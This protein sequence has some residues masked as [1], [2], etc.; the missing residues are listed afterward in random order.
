[1]MIPNSI[2]TATYA[3]ITL[4][5][6]RRLLKRLLPEVN[7]PC[8]VW[9]YFPDSNSMQTLI[10]LHDRYTAELIADM[11]RTAMPRHKIF[12]SPVSENE[13]NQAR[14]LLR[15]RKY[16]TNLSAV[17]LLLNDG[18]IDASERSKILYYLTR[19]LPERI[20][21]KDSLIIST[22]AVRCDKCGK[23][24]IKF[25][26]HCTNCDTR[27]PFPEND[28]MQGVTEWTCP[29]CKAK[30]EVAI[31]IAKCPDCGAGLTDAALDPAIGL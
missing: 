8:C 4:S 26:G 5:A 24:L 3:A 19:G 7:V 21:P 2:K 25:T 27:Y 6:F 30:Y 1:M 22:M 15:K 18:K 31:S 12:A 29:K 10:L 16:V 9:M 17:D 11:M 14:K 13:R 23:P 28:A 20:K